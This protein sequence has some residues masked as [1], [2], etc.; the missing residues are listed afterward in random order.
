MIDLSG[1]NP[2]ESGS[3]LAGIFIIFAL[4]V[5]NVMVGLWDERAAGNV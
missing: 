4:F 5:A 3:S 1:C 2:V